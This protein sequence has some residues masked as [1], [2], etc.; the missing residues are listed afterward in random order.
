[1]CISV[2]F[3]FI[4]MTPCNFLQFLTNFLALLYPQVRMKTRFIYISMIS[5]LWGQ[6]YN[7]TLHK[8]PNANNL[9]FFKEVSTTCSVMC[10]YRGNS[11]MFA[12]N[13]NKIKITDGC[14]LW[15]HMSHAQHI[16]FNFLLWISFIVSHHVSVLFDWRSNRNESIVYINAWHIPPP[17]SL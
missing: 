3:Q 6:R 17:I 8:N 4:I 14:T 5:S 15:S 12:S 10:S 11:D 1:M 13:H 7:C 16:V 9:R 2:V